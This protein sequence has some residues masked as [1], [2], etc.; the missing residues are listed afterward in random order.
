M[1]FHQ[2]L[3]L[4]VKTWPMCSSSTLAA[5][6]ENTLS[7]SRSST[8]GFPISIQEAADRRGQQIIIYTQSYVFSMNRFI[9]L[10]QYTDILF[11]KS[12]SSDKLRDANALKSA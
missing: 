10:A 2:L 5:Y 7:T 11:H 6:Q 12:S 3:L 8:S 4:E 9:L 1:A